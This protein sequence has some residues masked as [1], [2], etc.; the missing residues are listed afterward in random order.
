VARGLILIAVAGVALLGTVAPA[1]AALPY[2][3]SLSGCSP[4]LEQ[5]ARAVVFQGDMRRVRAGDRLEIRFDLLVRS[6]DL[7]WERLHYEGLGIWNRAEAGVARY[8]YTKRVENLAAPASYRAIVTFR[9]RDGATNRAH[10]R[11]VR[12]TPVCRQ[13]DLRPDLVVERVDGVRTGPQR[14]SYGVVVRNNGQ[15][16]TLVDTAV[17]LLVDGTAQTPAALAPLMPRTETT[18]RFTGPACTQS[19]EA[20]LDTDAAVDEADED[21]NLLAVPCPLAP[22]AAS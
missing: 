15:M 13:P 20:R 18:L 10:R 1:A 4:A 2:K 22:G 6:P 14:A 3:A 17:Q 16:A 7:G 5:S 8:T 9:W 21:N 19:V 11:E 12:R